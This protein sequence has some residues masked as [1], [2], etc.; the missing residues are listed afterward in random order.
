LDAAVLAGKP[1]VRGSRL[2]VDFMVGLLVDLQDYYFALNDRTSR[3]VVTQR[4]L[5]AIRIH[6]STVKPS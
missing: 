2:A 5:R 3:S 6:L 4:H 1:V